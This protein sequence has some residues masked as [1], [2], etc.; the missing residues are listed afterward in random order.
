MI[1]L[2]FL[3]GFRRVYIGCL[4]NYVSTYRFNWL[5]LYIVV[6]TPCV[7]IL[8][9]IIYT[10]YTHV[11]YHDCFLPKSGL[12]TTAP[13]QNGSSNLVAKGSVE[14]WKINIQMPMR[15]VANWH[16]KWL[17]WKMCKCPLRF[18]WKLILSCSVWF[19]SWFCFFW[20]GDGIW[21]YKHACIKQLGIQWISQHL[22]S[23]Q[24]G[25]LI[26][27]SGPVQDF[28]R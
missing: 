17:S 10:I 12:F 16:C 19:W 15:C 21:G 20:G 9:I 6:Y 4:W 11:I 5:I 8:C 18:T 2:S 27:Y 1:L 24:H 26:I 13:I 28:Q 7:C 22:W 25:H 14:V 3:Q 23:S